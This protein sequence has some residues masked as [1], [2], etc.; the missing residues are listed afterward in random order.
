MTTPSLLFVCVCVFSVAMSHF[1]VKGDG[2]VGS[3]VPHMATTTLIFSSDS[4]TEDSGP[5][6]RPQNR[7]REM[8]RKMKQKIAEEWEIDEDDYCVLTSP[9]STKVVRKKVAILF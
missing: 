2:E 5:I 1:S 7:E 6:K 9:T 4:E 3:A 8:D